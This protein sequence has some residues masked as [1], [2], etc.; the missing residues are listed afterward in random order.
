MTRMTFLALAVLLA[1]APPSFAQEMTVEEL[2][3]VALQRSPDLQA[4]RADIAI[5][6]G[7]VTQAGVRPNPMVAGSHEQGG[8]HMA[9]TMIGAE[10]P[11]ALRRRPARAAV[12]QR[13][14]DITALT[15]RERERL[16][17]SAVRAQAGRLLAAQR[18]LDI[19]SEAL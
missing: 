5:A 8:D 13:A 1:V 11:L 10:W 4:A 17:A 3:A 14:A 15:V 12:A 9:T 7:R 19:A 16:L 2:V 6:A 18:T